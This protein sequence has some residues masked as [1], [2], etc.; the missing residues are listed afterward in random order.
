MTTFHWHG[1]AYTLPPEAVPLY[2]SEG[3]PQQAF[4]WNNQVI[5]F[6]F[7]PE[8]TEE[9]VWLMLENGAEDLK[10][11]GPFTQNHDQIVEQI[12]NTKLGKELLFNLLDKF[13]CSDIA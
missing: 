4:I 12:S 13:I 11:T 3:C 10:K 8:A 7:H 5:G 6:Q 9:S 2:H 1:D